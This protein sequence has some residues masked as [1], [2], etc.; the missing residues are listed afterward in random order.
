MALRKML[1][2]LK[3]RKELVSKGEYEQDCVVAL[4]EK[5]KIKVVELSILIGKGQE[6]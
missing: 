1:H 6:Y 5:I 3:G 4:E 2:D